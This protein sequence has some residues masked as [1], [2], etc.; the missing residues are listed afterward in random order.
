[1]MPQ[2]WAPVSMPIWQSLASAG[3][4]G[5]LKIATN[6]APLNSENSAFAAFDKSVV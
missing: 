3:K 5:S 6:F 2:K 4:L 1:M